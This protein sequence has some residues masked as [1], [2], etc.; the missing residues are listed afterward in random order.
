[1]TDTET[2]I[3]FVASKPDIIKAVNSKIY[4]DEQDAIDAADLWNTGHRT[5]FNIYQA[6]VTKVEETQ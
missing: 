1:M 2:I 4:Y 3:F 5:P 6:I